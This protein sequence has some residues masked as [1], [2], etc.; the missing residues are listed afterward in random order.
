MET[1]GASLRYAVYDTAAGDLT[2]VVNDGQVV[3]ILFG[4]FDPPGMRNEENP[5]LYDAIIQINQYFFGQRKSFDLPLLLEGSDFAKKIY[6]YVLSIP[7]GETRTEKDVLEAIDARRSLG[8]LREVLRNNPLPFL[9]PSHRVLRGDNVKEL[10]LGYD[11]QSIL[12]EM[13][14]GT[15]KR[16]RP[17]KY[18]HPSI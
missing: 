6:Q 1:K 5:V 4:S 3:R 12:L 2:I 9:I 8:A 14:E 13:E 17:G 15:G 16:Y 10:P 7:Y 11:I 18:L